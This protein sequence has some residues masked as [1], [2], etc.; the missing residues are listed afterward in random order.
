MSF[1]S[2]SQIDTLR[3]HFRLPQQ[4][5][6]PHQIAVKLGILRSQAILILSLLEAEEATVNRLL[7]YHNCAEAPVDSMPYG[8]GFPS[9]PWIC[10]N[11]E[12]E[13]NSYEELDF[14]F[15]ARAEDTIDIV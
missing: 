10:P 9:L 6:M 7:I 12:H 2:D 4:T 11:C 8:I 1:L 15:I 3:E 13:V 5:C 14:D